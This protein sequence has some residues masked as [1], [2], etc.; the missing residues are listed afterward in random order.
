MACRHSS[1]APR[2]QVLCGRDRVGERRIHAGP[3][4]QD[5]GPRRPNRIRLGAEVHINCP[6]ERVLT[7]SQW[8][9]RLYLRNRPSRRRPRYRL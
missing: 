1:R 4:R 2:L 6:I 8:R 3:G 7:T 9:R 5:W